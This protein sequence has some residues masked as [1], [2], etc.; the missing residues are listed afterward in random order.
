MSWIEMLNKKKM[1]LS[2]RGDF[3]QIRLQ[4]IES[5]EQTQKTTKEIYCW[6]QIIHYFCAY[7][8]NITT[9]VI[10]NFKP[11]SLTTS[12][13]CHFNFRFKNNNDPKKWNALCNIHFSPNKSIVDRIVYASYSIW[14]FYKIWNIDMVIHRHRNYD[15][16]SNSIYFICVRLHSFI[17]VNWFSSNIS[18]SFIRMILKLLNFI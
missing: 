6:A 13:F 16:N 7:R 8:S 5:F 14:I 3:Q 10:W 17:M 2:A 1:V 11:V 18:I 15:C 12:A 9:I 4:N